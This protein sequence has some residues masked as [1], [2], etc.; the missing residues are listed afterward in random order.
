MSS[1]N[2]RE[3]E[4]VVLLLIMG[5]GIVATAL[6]HGVNIGRRWRPVARCQWTFAD[7]F[8]CRPLPPVGLDT[9]SG[10]IKP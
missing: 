1:N 5:L 2:G 4:A 10:E 9:P 6:W 8:A 7:G 3:R